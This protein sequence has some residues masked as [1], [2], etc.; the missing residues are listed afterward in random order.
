MKFSTEIFRNTSVAVLLT[1]VIGNLANA[2]QSPRF[3][4]KV[5]GITVG[6]D[7]IAKVRSLYGPGAE[8]TSAR[9]LSLC[10][11]FAQDNSY[12]SV[13]TFEGQARV[14]SVTLTTLADITPG[15]HDAIVKGKSPTGPGGIKM[16]DSIQKVIATIGK[17]LKTGKL[18]AGPHEMEFAD[19]AV[20][21][22]HATCQF[23]KG[24]LIIV[25]IELD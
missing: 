10:Y 9:I 25:S 3:G 14:R 19:Y 23:E 20:V 11:F 5:A 24:K 18:Q 16:G 7:T 8:S 21:G 6:E 4:R 1:I 22:G 17:P 2:A 15:C 13:S 12:L